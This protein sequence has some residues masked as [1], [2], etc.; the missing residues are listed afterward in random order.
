[1]QKSV[2]HAMGTEVELL[3]AGSLPAGARERI[4]KLFA[5][6]EACLSRFRPDSELSLLNL[7]AGAPFAASPLLREVLREALRAAARSDGLFDPTVWHAVRAAGYRESL[8]LVGERVQVK[9]PGRTGAWR[10]VQVEEDGTVTLPAGAGLDL[11]GFAK[12]WTVDRAA[13]LLEGCASWLIN[14]GGDLLA[15]GPGP[16]GDGWIIG[17][18]DPL[19]GPD[20][21]VLRVNDAAVATSSTRRRR[22][23]TTEGVAHHIIDPRTG[24]P[25]TTDLA[26]ATVVTESASEAEVLAKSL[27]LLG[28]S[29]ALRRAEERGLAA[30]LVSVDGRL[31]VTPVAEPFVVI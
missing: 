19:V 3:A 7:A 13:R 20:V 26:S 15:R 24:E 25:S 21:S 28:R 29:N 23:L 30:V 8:E 10:E 5:E 27:L 12:G 4:E 9:S 1:M 11:G 31:D 16:D 18:E 17:V 2:F 14:A 22:W 6:V